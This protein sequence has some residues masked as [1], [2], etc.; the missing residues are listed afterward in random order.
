MATSSP[1][2]GSGPSRRAAGFTL[3]EMLVALAVGAMFAASLAGLSRTISPRV[4]LNAAAERIAGDFERARLEARRTGAPV[5]IAL[6]ADGYQIEALELSGDWGGAEARLAGA[7]LQAQSW[8]IHPAPFASAFA[9]PPRGLVLV[10]GDLR[11]SL[12]IGPASGRAEVRLE[13]G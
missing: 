1:A 4:E 12:E 11:A 2:E 9:G 6:S 10:R 13:A 7:P 3:F 8:D 5:T